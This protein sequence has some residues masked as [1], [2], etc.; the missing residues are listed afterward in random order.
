MSGDFIPEADTPYTGIFKEGAKNIIIRLSA[1]RVVDFKKLK[2]GTS[3]EKADGKFM[4]GISIKI[5]ID[6][7]P[8]VNIIG[9][10][11]NK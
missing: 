3:G 4:P 7:K 5:L 11:S 9:A 1:L 2:I 10:Y 8:S 6:G